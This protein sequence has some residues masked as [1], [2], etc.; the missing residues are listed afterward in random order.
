MLHIRWRLRLALDGEPITV[1]AATDVIIKYVD[2]LDWVQ[3]VVHDAVL[4]RVVAMVDCVARLLV[5]HLLKVTWGQR[6]CMASTSLLRQG[7]R[8]GKHW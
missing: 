8:R 2:G 6:S 4:H 7:N 5:R 1:L 3:L